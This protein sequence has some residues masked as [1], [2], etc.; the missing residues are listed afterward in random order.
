MKPNAYIRNGSIYSMRRDMLEEGIRYG[1]EN[2]LAYIMPR[3]RT[4]NIDE[5][6]DFII[7]D[8]L[9]RQLLKF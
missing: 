5:P 1:T 8:Y 9:M 7:A 4:V 3:E 6:M 2:S